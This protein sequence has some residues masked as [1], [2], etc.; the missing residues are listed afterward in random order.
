M[1]IATVVAVLA[2]TLAASY[3]SFQPGQQAFALSVYWPAPSNY[4]PNSPPPNAYLQINYTGLGNAYYHYVVYS[5][6]AVLSEGNATVTHRSP[7]Y[8]YLNVPIPST[9]EAT[10]T[11]NGVTV[12]QGRLNLG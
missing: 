11:R 7:F 6:S 12:Y 4:L 3:S 5:N 1:P 8:L 9:L 10:V 2:V